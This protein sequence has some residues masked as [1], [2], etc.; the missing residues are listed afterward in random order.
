MTIFYVE[1]STPFCLPVRSAM[2]LARVPCWR[3]PMGDGL[4]TSNDF[5]K[6]RPECG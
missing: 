6:S 1:G 2:E 4:L 5:N 3:F